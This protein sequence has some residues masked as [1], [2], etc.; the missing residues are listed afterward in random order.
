M[1]ELLIAEADTDT[2]AKRKPARPD[3]DG[4]DAGLVT[5]LAERAG[6]A[7]LPPTGEG[8]LLEQLPSRMLALA[9][10]D[11]LTKHRAVYSPTAI[12]S[13]NARIRRSMRVRCHVRTMPS[14]HNVYLDVLGLD[15]PGRTVDAGARAE[16]RAPCLRGHL[17][18]IGE[19]L[20]TRRA[21]PLVSRIH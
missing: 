21:A 7:E 8:G 20:S 15:P 5:Q 9:L 17:M 14:L 1:S 2:V 11:E 3:P 6:P 4:V 18:A 10:Q 13:I 12:D 16:S 19:Q